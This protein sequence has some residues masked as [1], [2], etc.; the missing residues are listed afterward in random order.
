MK[1]HMFKMFGI[2]TKI[3]YR[4]P[5]WNLL[6]FYNWKNPNK[7]FAV[8][9]KG[10]DIS[11]DKL[12]NILVYFVLFNRDLEKKAFS[13]SFFDVT[14]TSVMSQISDSGVSESWHG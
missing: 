2:K 4:N 12:I 5:Q 7:M 3:G 10:G 13:F 6:T 8:Q 14:I 1:K 11:F 9:K